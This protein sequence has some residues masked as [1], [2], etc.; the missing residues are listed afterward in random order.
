[1]ERYTKKQI[2]FTVDQ[3]FKNYEAIVRNFRPKY[4]RNS[5]LTSSNVKRLLNQ[6]RETDSI[7]DLGLSGLSTSRS[8]ERIKAI[9]ESDEE[10]S[11]T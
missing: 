11:G 7:S 2:V 4:G 10:R 6:F 8:T 5:D 3:Y 1:M 9:R